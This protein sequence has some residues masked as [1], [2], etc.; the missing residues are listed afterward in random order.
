MKR[1]GIYLMALWVFATVACSEDDKLIDGLF[2]TV[3]QGAV[4]RTVATSTG[5]LNVLDESASVTIEVEEQDN[6]NG[7]LLSEVRVFVNLTDNTPDATTSTAEAALTVIPGSDF[8]SGPFGLPRGSFSTTLGE[9]ATALGLSVGDYNCGD[10]FVLRLELELTDGRVFTDVDVTGTVQG[11]SFFSSPFQYTLNLVAELPSDDLYTGDYQVTQTAPGI[12]STND[13]VDGVYTLESVNNTTKI[14][15]QIPTFAAFGPFG[16]VDVEFQLICGEIVM[17]PGQDVGAGC[18][19]SIN[20]G[21]ASV[22][23]TYDLNNPDDSDFVIN[24]TSDESD[25]CG[26]GTAQ[27]S[28]R[29]T[30]I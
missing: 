26:Q 14:I 2:E 22:N 19:G 3:E 11:G 27:A 9:M 21:P 18:N 20:S 8:S 16:P 10:A 23:S 1:K 29:L 17:T 24:F 12:F 6:E 5:A 15:Q 28:I 30:K 13:Y 7:A 25:D 4:L